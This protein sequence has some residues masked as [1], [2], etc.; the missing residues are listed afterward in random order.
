MLVRGN[1][2]DGCLIYMYIAS[3]SGQSSLHRISKWYENI[4]GKWMQQRRL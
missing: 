1:T 4:A 3:A 2:F